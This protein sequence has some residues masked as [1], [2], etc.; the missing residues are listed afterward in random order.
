MQAFSAVV[1]EGSFSKAAENLNISPQLVSKYVSQLETYLNTRLLNRTTRKVSVTEAGVAYFK[2]CQQVLLEIDE[3]EMALGELHDNITGVLN[4]S[5]PMSFGIAHLAKAL[6]E[7]QLLYPKVKI[8][9]QLNDRKIDI[10]EE[11]FDIVLRIGHLKDS[12]LI[13]KKIAPIR[14]VTC[15][16]PAYLNQYGEPKHPSELNEHHFLRYSYME[17]HAIYPESAEG[18][19]APLKFKNEF[20]AN[21][22]DVLVNAAIEGAGITIQ[23]TFIAGKTISE[24]KLVE[25]LKDY[26]PEARGLYAV[27]VHRNYLSSKVRSFIDFLNGYFGSPPYWDQF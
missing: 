26:E 23:P 9:L 17:A 3:M 8:N 22:G 24:G 11:G 21:N 12:S 1:S 18:T 4:I 19:K 2:R 25:L 15:A 7:F 14:M 20:V 27:Y 5:A 10:V 6:V 16:S 13:A